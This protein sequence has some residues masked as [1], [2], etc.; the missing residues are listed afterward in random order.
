MTQSKCK[1]A[2]GLLKSN[3]LIV[4]PTH[5]LSSNLV[6]KPSKILIF[7]L[8]QK[9]NFKILASWL[10]KKCVQTCMYYLTKSDVNLAVYGTKS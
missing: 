8:A 10:S 4:F 1:T 7:K 5:C 2:K 9:L 3:L 6:L